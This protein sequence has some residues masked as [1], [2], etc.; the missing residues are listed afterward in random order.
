MVK[1]CRTKSAGFWKDSLLVKVPQAILRSSTFL[2]LFLCFVIGL[3]ADCTL[4]FCVDL[5]IGRQAVIH[6][7]IN[8]L[9]YMTILFLMIKLIS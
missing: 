4:D 8:I 2:V 7:K 5:P 1:H 3:L 9:D 6:N